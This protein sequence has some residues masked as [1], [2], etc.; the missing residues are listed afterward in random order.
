MLANGCAN[1]RVK[2]LFITVICMALVCGVQAAT[3]PI[4]GPTT[5]T[6]PGYYV[7]QNYIL[8]SQE[9]I[10]IKI[11]ASDVTLDGNGHTIDG[12]KSADSTGI[13]LN[14]A[15]DTMS[16]VVIKNVVLRE[17]QSG[18]SLSRVKGGTLENVK[19]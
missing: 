6:A 17:W 8:N 10:C 5:I 11:T 3:I 16:N 2:V 12:M 1:M 14:P 9:P 4:T 15:G 7:L 18:I 13:L 19:G